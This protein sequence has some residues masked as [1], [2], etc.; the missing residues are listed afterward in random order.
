MEAKKVIDEGQLDTRER[1]LNT[2]QRL[3]A[4][5]GFKATSLRHITQEANANV[6]AVN[7]H[8]GSK[9]EML[10]E[11]IRRRVEPINDRRYALLEK[12]RAEA[13]GQPIPLEKIFEALFL[14]F[15]Q[16]VAP[17][18]EKDKMNLI[19]IIERVLSEQPTLMRSVYEEHFKKLTITIMEALSETMPELETA[20][21][22]WRFHFALSLMLSSMTTRQRIGHTSKGLCD[23][24][25]I[26]EMVTR[27]IQFIC[28]G[29]R[30]K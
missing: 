28:A 6:A 12:Y 4:E 11:L 30:A 27:L 15:F 21:L 8:F 18:T 2:A 19:R 7:Y 3:F 29:F 14:P 17:D 9:E 1:L 26:E 10:N 23:P 16:A 24:E 5:Q 20:E 13:G 25:D 22:H